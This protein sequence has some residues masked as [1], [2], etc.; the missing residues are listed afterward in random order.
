MSCVEPQISAIRWPELINRRQV[1]NNM[2]LSS[3]VTCEGASSEYSQMVSDRGWWVCQ[4]G[5]MSNHSWHSLVSVLIWNSVAQF[6]AQFECVSLEYGQIISGT[7]WW[8]C[9]FGIRLHNFRHSLVDVPILRRSNHFWHSLMGVPIWNT[10]KSFL[11]QL[12]LP[13]WNTVTPFLAQ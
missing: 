3:D 5:I 13:L 8:V 1:L 10:V 2:S 12:G 6:V 9:Q 11:A 7:V 4:F